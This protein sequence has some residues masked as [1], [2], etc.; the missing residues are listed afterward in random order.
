MLKAWAGYHGECKVDRQ[1]S[2]IDDE[3]MLVHNDLC[4]PMGESFFQIDTLIFTR[5][6]ILILEIKN[7]AGSM[8]Y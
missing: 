4:I 7:I 1:L 3:H 5:N 2:T 8:E 6:F